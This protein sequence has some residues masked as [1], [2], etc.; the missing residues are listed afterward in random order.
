MK[1]Y[2]CR[3]QWRQ[4]WDFPQIWET[5]QLQQRLWLLW[6]NP[7]FPS[8]ATAVLRL[9]RYINHT[10]LSR[11]WE[12]SCDRCCRWARNYLTYI[13]K[14]LS[15]ILLQ[16]KEEVANSYGRQWA[17]L[18]GLP[19]LHWR[20]FSLCKIWIAVSQVG[21]LAAVLAYQ[22]HDLCWADPFNSPLQFVYM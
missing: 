3:I 17:F 21:A 7:D 20:P 19:P 5:F 10:C 15:N 16:V 12:G 4:S 8:S 18:H 6:A 9:Q 22:G 13:L 2:P 14:E 11:I 1:M